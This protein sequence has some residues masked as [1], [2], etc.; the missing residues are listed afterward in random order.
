MNQASSTRQLLEERVLAAQSYL[1]P[2][3]QFDKLAAGLKQMPDD[4]FEQMCAELAEA[5][6]GENS[7]TTKDFV[8]VIRQG[9]QLFGTTPENQASFVK[10]SFMSDADNDELWKQISKS[11]PSDIIK[12]DRESDSKII[13][14]WEDCNPAFVTT[15]GVTIPSD[16]F[17][18]ETIPLKDVR[19]VVDERKHP[20]GVVTSY[21]VVIFDDY[22]ERVKL[23]DENTPQM[24][25]ATIEYIGNEPKIIYPINILKGV[26]IVLG[27]AL[28]HRN[29]TPEA[30]TRFEDLPEA[31]VG[32]HAVSLLETWYGIQIALLHPV[33]KDVF[34]RPRTIV[35]RDYRHKGKGRKRKV[36][37]IKQHVINA[38]A[39]DIALDGGSPGI[40]RRTLAWY[41]IGHWRTYPDG[42]KVFI[43]P[44]WKGA[45]RDL[46]RNFTER[47]REIAQISI[48]T[49]A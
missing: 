46:R 7:L 33:V 14:L 23:A 48:D 12:L 21:R 32:Q 6:K 16:L 15:S 37:Y 28:G 40:T 3:D 19:I 35:D 26:D 29:L 49:A 5:Y 30:K 4:E 11:H 41:V 17:F 36:K 9:R 8:N 10:V 20:D 42:R 18:A 31:D 25:G 47:E 22:A 13:H 27:G 24:V 44:Y 34:R 43:K 38:T 45:L 1:L 2:K 39:I